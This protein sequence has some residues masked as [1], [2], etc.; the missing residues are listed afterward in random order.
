MGEVIRKWNIALDLNTAK[1]QKHWESKRLLNINKIIERV[2]KWRW[3]ENYWTNKKYRDNQEPDD[4]EKQAHSF[5]NNFVTHKRAK[6]RTTSWIETGF[7]R[8]RSTVSAERS[9]ER[10]QT[11]RRSRSVALCEDAIAMWQWTK[12]LYHMGHW[13]QMQVIRVHGVDPPDTSQLLC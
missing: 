6:T 11:L 7:P 8:I 2:H 10:T 5:C 12:I 4:V 3:E 13:T 9:Q 1:S